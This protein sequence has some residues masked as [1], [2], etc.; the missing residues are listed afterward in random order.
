MLQP[1][2]FYRELDRVLH[3]INVGAGDPDWFCWI[4]GEIV[5]RFGKALSITSGRLYAEEDEGFRLEH[6]CGSLD[7]K[8]SGLLIPLDYRPLQLVL[9][10]GVFIFDETVPGQSPE[11]EKRLG[12]I[13]S[14]A[15]LIDAEPR[16]ILAFGLAEGWERDHLDFA[17]RTIRNS[18]RHRLADVGLKSDLAQAAEIQRSLLPRR[19]PEFPSY[20]IA[21][22]SYAADTVGGDFYDFLPVAPDILGIATGDA[23]GHGLGA[24]LLARDVVTGLRMGAERDL[25][26]TAMISRLNRVVSRSMLSTRFVSLFYGELEKN[27]NLFYV[28]AGHLEPWL[29]GTR[30][31]RRLELGGTI[32]GP[33]LESTFHRG[34]AHVDRGDTFL[35]LTDGVVERKNLR[36]EMFG[37]AGVERIVR[38]TH[39]AEAQE[40]L[41]RLIAASRDHGAGHPWADD[42]TAVVITRDAKP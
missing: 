39:G 16:H 37:E 20:R 31:L 18:I 6:D 34:F 38:E 2:V 11:L 26:I 22:A 32:L 23:S 29:F 15:L 27:G 5:D 19:L 3:D 7:P 36:G 8:V 25:K 24:A 42:T 9:E 40:I 33:L 12:G 41:S 14:A 21:A 30:G 4:V 13:Q 10:H 17:L 28:N 1:K 35:V